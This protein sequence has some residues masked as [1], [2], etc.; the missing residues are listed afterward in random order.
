MK[1]SRK[2]EVWSVCSWIILGLLILFLIYPLC[3]IL[4]QS[5]TL[6]DGTVGL[7]RYREIFTNP[8]YLESI[9]NSFKVSLTSTFFALLVGIPFAYFYAFY[10]IKGSKLLFTVSIL[11]CMSAPFIGAYAWILLLGRAGEI[12]MLIR[13]LFGVRLGSIYGFHGIVLVQVTKLYPLVFLSLVGVFRNIDNSLMEASLNLGCS[14]LKRFFKVLLMLS[15]PTIFA[16]ALL[17]FMQ[18][19]A[20]FGTP[21]LIGQ[22]FKTFSVKIYESYMSET[23]NDKT[24]AAAL[25]VIAIFITGIIFLVQKVGADRF[26]FTINALHPIEPKKLKGISTVFVYI[27]MYGLVGVSFLPNIYLVYCSFRNSKGTVFHDGYSLMNYQKAAE[28]LMGRSF[29]N[30]IMMGFL[31]L[32]III[33]ISVIISYL[34]VRRKNL[35]NNSIDTL[36]MIPFIMPGSIVGIALISSFNAGIM[37]SG[38]LVLAGTYSIMILALVIRRMSYTIRSTTATLMQIS[39]SVEEAAISLGAS[40]MKTFFAITV[41]MM[42]NGIISGAI[43]SFTAI[44]TE[45]STGILMY[46]NKTITLTISTYLQVVKGFYGTACA[47]A[48]V[49]LA[50]TTMAVMLYLKVTKAEDVRL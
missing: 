36:A 25:S 48:T 11:S 27:F 7:A 23:G 20:D 34:V 33:V 21:L 37:N 16:A 13:Q 39:I 35:L 40:K 12:T 17:V 24:L 46:T 5:V 22:N 30:T 41:P 1:L 47:F 49:L 50:L 14:G 31:S 28:Q 43:L 29:F 38:I 26:K 3:Y 10:Q 15:M 45:L 32:A 2:P 4:K 9:A 6:A 19:F 8:T 44:I 18:C 42:K